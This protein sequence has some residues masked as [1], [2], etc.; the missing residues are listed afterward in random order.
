MAPETAG[1]ASGTLSVFAALFA[2]TFTPS[3][4]QVLVHLLLCRPAVLTNENPFFLL[5]EK[6]LYRA[7]LQSLTPVHERLVIT[8]GMLDVSRCR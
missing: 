2:A 3:L 5:Q 8:L 1:V 7:K 6:A 4:K